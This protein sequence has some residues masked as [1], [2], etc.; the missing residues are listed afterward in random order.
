MLARIA[1]RGASSISRQVHGKILP[2]RGVSPATNRTNQLSRSAA[3]HATTTN[4]CRY[5]ST[6]SPSSSTTPFAPDELT[7]DMALGIADATQFFIRYGLAQRR[8]QA[9]ADSQ[10]ASAPSSSVLGQWQTMIE[11]YLATQ[12]HVL[13]GMGYADTTNGNAQELGL[14]KYAQDLSSLLERTD[15]A[16]RDAIVSTRRE[17]WR[18]LVGA[19]YGF[20]ADNDIPTLSIVQAR[21]MMH[22][23]SSRM[24]EPDLLLAV[25]SQTA[26]VND[27]DPEVELQ[28]KHQILQEVIVNQ[29]YLGQGSNSSS[30][31][32]PERFGFGSGPQAYAKLQCAMSDYEGDPLIGQYAASAMSKL[33]AAAGLDNLLGEEN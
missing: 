31:S 18:E 30:P 22:A 28:K 2:C 19:A 3:P 12:L 5:F 20:D 32:I 6:E 27:P 15:D 4:P 10:D 16:T 11:I 21:E 1:T 13:A 14:T 23:V 24:V 17:T 8:L 25:Q 7:P 9:L 29:V 26:K 33:F